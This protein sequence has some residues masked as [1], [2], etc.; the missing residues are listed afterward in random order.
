MGKLY[1]GRR[2]GSRWALIGG[3]QRGAPM[4]ARGAYLVINQV[5]AVLCSLLWGLLLGLLDQLLEIVVWLPAS[6]TGRSQADFLGWFLHV[7]GQSSTFI[8]V[9]PV[10][11]C[12]FNLLVHSHST[13]KKGTQSISVQFTE[14]LSITTTQGPAFIFIFCTF[15]S[16]ETCGQGAFW[17]AEWTLSMCFFN[18]GVQVG[19]TSCGPPRTFSMK[20]S[21]RRHNGQ[22][23]RFP[24]SASAPWITFLHIPGP[25][26]ASQRACLEIQFHHSLWEIIISQNL[27]LHLQNGANT[28]AGSPRVAVRMK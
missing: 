4:M 6:L 19:L 28:H 13:H 12:I 24:Q 18:P 16:S 5:L 10:C 22:Q 1:G 27:F 8:M 2:A 11:I 7:V 3:G 21:L 9:C 20:S 23:P 25:R 26:G 17:V 14:R 15:F